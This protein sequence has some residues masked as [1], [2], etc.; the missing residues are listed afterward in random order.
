MQLVGG[1]LSLGHCC[2][3]FFWIGKGRGQLLGGDRNPE[4]VATGH[5]TIDGEVEA[6]GRPRQLIDE[7]GLGLAGLLIGTTSRL[8]QGSCGSSVGTAGERRY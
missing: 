4:K 5:L 7:E 3:V 2:F 8:R 1:T 6:L